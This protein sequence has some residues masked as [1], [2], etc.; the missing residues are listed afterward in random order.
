MRELCIF[1]EFPAT[2]KCKVAKVRVMIEMDEKIGADRFPGCCLNG[3]GRWWERNQL[4]MEHWSG[5]FLVN[6]ALR[7]GFFNQIIKWK[8]R[9]I[10]VTEQHQ[11]FHLLF[12]E[13]IR[14]ASNPSSHS[15]LALV[16]HTHCQPSCLSL[17]PTLIRII[18]HTH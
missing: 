3:I 2:Y 8:L 12:K 17:S 7:K 13:E 16:S 6:M 10:A 4:I 14:W 18:L 11:L 15:S 5:R 9:P 1:D